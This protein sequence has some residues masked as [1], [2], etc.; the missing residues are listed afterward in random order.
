MVESVKIK[1]IVKF[2]FKMLIFRNLV[3]LK[4]Q[5]MYEFK[6]TLRNKA[7]K[8]DKAVKFRSRLYFI[9]IFD[10]CLLIEFKELSKLC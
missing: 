9:I 7:V 2:M 3:V 6:V 4:C 8:M 5:N 10:S 1:R